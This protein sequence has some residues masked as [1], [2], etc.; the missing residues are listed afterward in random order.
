MAIIDFTL[1]PAWKRIVTDD[2]TAAPDEMDA[3]E[4]SEA[5]DPEGTTVVEIVDEEQ[6]A[7]KRR[8]VTPRRMMALGAVIGTIAVVRRLRRVISREVP[9]AESTIDVETPDD[10]EVEA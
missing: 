10:H 8:L 1:A 9:D 7:P 2:E 4:Q 3:T 6:D 5:T